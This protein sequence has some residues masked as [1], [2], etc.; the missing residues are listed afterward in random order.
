[1]ISKIEFIH[2]FGI[3]KDFNWNTVSNLEV[4]KE[5]NI[6]YGWNY[7]GKTTFSRIFSSLRDRNIYSDFSTGDFKVVTTSNGSFTKTNLA[8]FPY[9]VLVFNSDYIKENLKFDYEGDIK[10]IFFEV[11]ED[12]KIAK[13]IEQLEKEILEIEGNDSTIGKKNKYQ[14]AIEEYEVFENSLFTIEAKKIKDEHFISLIN[15]NKSNLRSIKD[16]II[17]NIEAQII[18]DK[19]ELSKVSKLIKVENPKPELNSVIF[20]INYQSLKKTVDETLALAPAKSDVIAILDKRKDAYNW[21]QNGLK[22]QRG[23]KKCF[24]C[25]NIITDERIEQLNS[26]FESK[27]SVLKE[28]C[29]EIKMQINKEIEYTK[30]I[31]FPNSHND[32]N[33]G[34]QEEYLVVKKEIND[35]LEEYIKHLQLLIKKIEIKSNKNIYSSLSGIENFKIDNIEKCIKQINELIQNNNKFS[36]NFFSIVNMERDRYKNHLVACFLK[37]YQ[38]ITKEKKA[39]KAYAEISNL[40]DQVNEYQKEIRRLN[41]SKESY[42]EG[43]VQFEA[44]IQSF[45]GRDDIAIKLNE[46][47]NRFNLLRGN[48]LAKNLSEGEKMAIA[49]S[50]FLVTIKSI[51]DKNR[52]SD[53]IVF[54]DDPISSLDGNHI[55]QINSLLKDTLF[56]NILDPN[57]PK[58][59]MWNLK[60]KQL[61][62]S[63]HNFD[64]FNLLKELPKKG[65]KKDSRYFISRS[66]TK[67]TIEKLPDVYNDY[68]SEYHYLFCEIMTFYKEMNKASYPKLL[69]MPNI[70]RRFLEMYTLTQ[71]PIKGELDERAD[72]IFGKRLSK[73]ICKPFH[74]F[75]HF[76]NI[77]RITKQSEFIAD[78]GNACEELINFFEAKNDKHYQALKQ[79]I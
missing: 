27:A 26:Y 45:L 46:G 70:L 51:Q 63:T 35:I 60:C 76:N 38:Y 19:N 41:A 21:V 69:L 68:Q 11:G 15:F 30:Q 59:K 28:K 29:E 71:Y 49:F 24:F 18:K 48:E 14:K 78:I 79:N 12:V 6:I 53:Y 66:S 1:M 56:E 55:F 36:A 32:F 25:D 7:S 40:N 5:K 77:D 73:R 72:E 67:S 52:F 61:F 75:S 42:S 22:I 44:F 3:Y 50:H 62:I 58:Q 39:Q 37:E 4:F 65:F 20:N 8:C 64:F 57:N 17:S 13:K 34:F 33:K 31:Q 16:Y 43:C 47:T 10:A 2:D 74:F 23:E 9:E 54:I